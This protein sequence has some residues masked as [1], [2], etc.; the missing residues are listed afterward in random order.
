MLVAG[1]VLNPVS[2]ELFLAER[3]KGAFLNDK[4]IRVAARKNMGEAV[5]SCGLAALRTRRPRIVPQG[6]QP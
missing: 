6:I 4:R 3:G 1:L 5:L 2:D